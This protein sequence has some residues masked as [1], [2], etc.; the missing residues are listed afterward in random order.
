MWGRSFAREFGGEIIKASARGGGGR[1]AGLLRSGSHG[2]S[3]GEGGAAG[4]FVSEPAA[5]QFTVGKIER[6]IGT[7]TVTRPGSICLELKVGDSVFQ[8]DVIETTAGGQVS[9]RFIDG[10]VFNLSNSARM[11]LKEFP[12][13][14][15][16]QPALF[17]V[18]RGD[19]AF[20]AGKMA[21][22]GRL[23]IDT[24]VASIRGRTQVG[25]IGTLSLI[26]LFFA[27]M[28][29]VQAAPSNVAHTDDE[30]IPIDYTSEPHGSFEL[31]TKEAT[32]RHFFVADPGVTWSFRLSSS[33]ELTVSQSANSPARMEQL[34]TIQQNVLH[35]YS[36]GLQAMQGPTFNGQ[37]GSTTNPNFREVLPSGARP[38][39][40]QPDNSGSSQSLTTTSLEVTNSSSGA[41]KTSGATTSVSDFDATSPTSLALDSIFVPPAPP[42]AALPSAPPAPVITTTAPAQN[43]ASSIDIAGTAEANSTVTLFNNSSTVGTATADSSGHWSVPGVALSSGIDY[44][45]TATATDAAG[46]SMPSTALA[47]HDTQTTGPTA[48]ATVTA[49]SADTGTAG[50]F[51]TSVAAQTVSGTFTGTLGAGEKIQVS[52]DGG[53]TWV[54]ATPGAGSSWTASGVTLSAGTGALAVRTIDT[55]SNT[56]AGSGHSYTLQTT[57]PTAVATVTALSADTGTAGD[58]ITSVAA[59]TVSGTFTGTLGAGEKIQVSADGGTTWVDATPGA[60]SSWTASGVTLSAGTGTL[61][62]RTID[63]A[64]NTTA[65]SGHSYTLDFDGAE[66]DV[67]DR[68]ADQRYRG[69]ELRLHHQQWWRA[70]CRHGRRHRR[71]RHR[72]RA[73]L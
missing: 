70:F 14:G 48:V 9:I 52:A 64:S 19:F 62:V 50:D 23:E 3:D 66:R 51:I 32:P 31:V 5:P 67:P 60:G 46:T 35:T 58:F 17:D 16:S 55:A 2:S 38:I 44:S 18:A 43:N 65:G 25:G 33:S 72:Q 59:Q 39:N 61:S 69:V 7:A 21:K 34:H 1:G 49:L 28:E 29:K 27:A 45:F 24:P 53:T 42:P 11:A 36:V 20:V 10:T 4:S 6:V 37:N 68:D 63:T 8:G 13:D 26:S 12:D 40:F 22:A 15:T 57:G 71:R 73:G 47:F 30:L 41:S 54:D 56:T